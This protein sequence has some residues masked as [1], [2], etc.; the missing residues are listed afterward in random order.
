MISSYCLAF[1]SH[2][3]RHYS[4]YQMTGEEKRRNDVQCMRTEHAL[5]PTIT[6]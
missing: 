4:Q 6:I 1:G 5:K 2:V 3:E